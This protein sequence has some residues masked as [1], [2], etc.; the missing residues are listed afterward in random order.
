MSERAINCSRWAGWSDLPVDLL[1]GILPLLEL[2][3]ALAFGAVYASWRSASTA[4]GSLPRT[5]RTPW[6]VSLAEEP[7][8]V[9]D[10]QLPKYRGFW[11]PAATSELRNLQDAERTFRVTFPG[12]QAVALCGA[13]HGWL[14]VANQISDLVLYDPFTAAL[15]P[16]PPIT[17]FTTCVEG[18]YRDGEGKTLVGYR[19]EWCTRDDVFDVHSLGGY[20]YDKVVLSGPPTTG[21]TVALAIHL[22]GKRLS[23]ARVGDSS[24]QQIS[25]IRTGTDS[26]ADCVYHGGRFYAV[27]MEGK[28]ESWDFGGG[29]DKPRK[30][31]VIAEDNF[32]MFED[33]VITRYLLSAPWGHLLQ[34]LVFFDTRRENTAR[35]EI[36]RLDLKSQ[37]MVRL[38]SA[39]ALQGHAAFVGQNSSPSILSTEEFPELRPDCIYFTTARLRNHSAYESNRNEW[40]GVSVYDLGRQ[41]LEPAFPSGGGHYG[42]IYPSEVWF[43]PS[44]K[45]HFGL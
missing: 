11:Y 43:T 37:T 44:V 14:I 12:G 34:V 33:A 10:Q 32:H 18:V 26:Y 3:E 15:L 42:T 30:K 38:S 16:L 2:P 39:E 1:I 9:E 45:S 21:P 19:Y 40:C 17:G 28:L 25:V 41:T 23:F 4:A 8:P 31:T 22:D 7:L 13:S 29:P 35:V 6:L 27:T 20:F 24:W 36:D 5:R